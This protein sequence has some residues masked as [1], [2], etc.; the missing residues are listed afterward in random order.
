MDAH[1]ER[2]RGGR[3]PEWALRDYGPQ[4]VPPR[5]HSY[6]FRPVI[7]YIKL[8]SVKK[9]R[10]HVHIVLR[11]KH[12]GDPDEQVVHLTGLTQTEA[13]ATAKMLILGGRQL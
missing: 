2:V 9:R 8:G 6:S 11:T 7:G 12:W 3:H 10:W 5:G 13:L 1:W 4:G